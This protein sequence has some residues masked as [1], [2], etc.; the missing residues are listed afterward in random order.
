RFLPERAAPDVGQM[1][2]LIDDLHAGHDGLHLYSQLA[3]R[4]AGGDAWVLVVVDQFEEVFTYRPQD[5]Q[6]RKRFQSN[7]EAFFAN[8]LHAAARPS[9]RV[10]VVLTMRSD[11][12]GSCASF[13]QLNEALNAHMIQVGPMG[14][15]DLRE[16]IERPAYLVGCEAEP[17]L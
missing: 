12:L 10:A 2:K 17:A 16:V 9:G 5:E 8:L 3:L 6:V 7:R 4:A 15:Q 13:S 1:R 11:F 14:G